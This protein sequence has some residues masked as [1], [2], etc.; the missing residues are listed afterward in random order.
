MKFKP[1]LPTLREKKRY[2]LFQFFSNKNFLYEDVKEIIFS[3]LLELYGEI[4]IGYIGPI[5]L[6][7]FWIKEKNVGILRVSHKYVEQAKL[8]IISIKSI[9]GEKVIPRILYVTGTLR[10]ARKIL[11]SL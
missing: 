3:K 11:N 10:K 8:A 9:R 1:I 5:F 7:E 2:I 4:G 6:P